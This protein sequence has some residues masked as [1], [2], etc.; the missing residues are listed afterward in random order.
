[1]EAGAPREA[2]PPAAD[3]ARSAVHGSAA[4]ALLAGERAVPTRSTLGLAE[5]GAAA[6]RSPSTTP[7]LATMAPNAANAASAASAS[8][9]ATDTATA[10]ATPSTGDAPLAPLP[11]LPSATATAPPPPSSADLAAPAGAAPTE[12]TAE[13][14]AP[15][16]GVPPAGPRPSAATAADRPAAA[17][18]TSTESVMLAGT[19]TP[20]DSTRPPPPKPEGERRLARSAEP[21]PAAADPALAA[22]TGQPQHRDG[23]AAG[24]PTRADA[25]ADRPGPRGTPTGPTART[26][27]ADSAADLATRA[28]AGEAVARAAGQPGREQAH[29]DTQARGEHLAASVGTPISADTSAG[30]PLRFGEQLQALMPA[31]QTPGH[32]AA[33]PATARIA[34]PMQAPDFAPALGSQVTLFARDGIQH[35]RIELNPAEMGPISVQIVLDG[36]AAKVDFHAEAALTRQAIESSLP[37]LAGAL[38]DAGLTLAGGGVFQQPAGQQNGQHN[39]AQGGQGGGSARGPRDAG[40]A[41]AGTTPATV[42]RTSARRGLVDL[43]A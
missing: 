16:T 26:N 3:A 40:E 22:A 32:S 35:A 17:D 5:A 2:Q 8:T 18:A 24:L 19:T 27:G 37:S 34:V 41:D 36:S 28:A 15:T 33:Q 14:P 25:A 10:A 7:T 38:R 21:P 6:R 30:T 29:A 13:P 9:A 20:L 1:P 43:V 4:A 11:G 23:V 39:G 12:A 42:L 31:S